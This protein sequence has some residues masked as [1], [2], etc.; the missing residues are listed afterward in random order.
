[1]TLE[2]VSLNGSSTPTDVA[3][4]TGMLTTWLAEI[5]LEAVPAKV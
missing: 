3:G 5:H 2:T 1:M 4:P